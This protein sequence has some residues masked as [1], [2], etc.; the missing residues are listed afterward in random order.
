MA[1]P[2][3]LSEIA[4]EL[5]PYQVVLPEPA[6]D[7]LSH[8]LALLLRW[9]QR[10]NL[11]GIRE[12]R[13]IVRQLFGESLFLAAVLDL[14]GWLVDIGSGAGF[15][16]LALKLVAPGLKVTLIEARRK[17]CA[18][19]REV[20]RECGFYGVDVVPE[21]F[22]DWCSSGKGQEKPN[23][24]TTRAVDVQKSLLSLI[25]V[26]LSQGGKAAFLT[27]GTLADGVCHGGEGLNWDLPIQIPQ[28][29]NR[30][31]LIG[32]AS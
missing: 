15:P 22:E 8:Y 27:S 11:T 9:N 24:I 12:P 2:L 28:S 26:G 16:G 3:S 20:A 10:M 4:R 29:H 30:V 31:V 23:L 25:A 14:R 17:K 6:L 7:Q 1:A 13:A 32:A 19:L 18:F 21:R 5:I